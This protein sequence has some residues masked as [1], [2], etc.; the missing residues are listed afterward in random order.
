MRALLLWTSNQPWNSAGTCRHWKSCSRGCAG[1]LVWGS[2]LSVPVQLATACRRSRTSAPAGQ[3]ARLLDRKYFPG[4]RSHPIV[5]VRVRPL[6]NE[7]G[8]KLRRIARHGQDAT[9]V[10]RAQVI[11]AST[12]GASPSKISEI[13]LLGEDYIRELIYAFNEDRFAMLKRKWGPGRPPK[14]TEE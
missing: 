4:E 3:V 11:M 9:E 6:I 2:W 12:Q 14:F 8:N 7:E 10:K 13:A 1:S 5:I